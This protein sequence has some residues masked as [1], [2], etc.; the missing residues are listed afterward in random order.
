M[1]FATIYSFM[2]TSVSLSAVEDLDLVKMF[3]FINAISS[4]LRFNE[5]HYN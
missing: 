3:V 2:K 4:A 5:S 1:D